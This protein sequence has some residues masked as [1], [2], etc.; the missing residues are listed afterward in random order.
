MAQN[1]PVERAEHSG[2]VSQ[3]GLGSRHT[4]AKPPNHLLDYIAPVPSDAELLRAEA[5]L[6][7]NR[8]LDAAEIVDRVIARNPTNIDAHIVAAAAWMRAG[9]YDR[10]EQ[11]L[12]YI[13]R[14]TQRHMGAI[15]L[16]GVLALLR[17]QESIALDQIRILKMLCG[18]DRCHEITMLNR[19][20]RGMPM[21]P[22]TP[23]E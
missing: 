22:E 5:L 23:K 8:P 20:L 1:V 11:A 18:S 17:G 14:I 12:G 15:Y 7:N 2:I 3:L 6:A 9:R 4:T 21:T 10:A 16:K 19:A 13:G